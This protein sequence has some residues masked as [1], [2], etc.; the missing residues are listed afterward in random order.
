MCDARP[1][2]YVAKT[3]SS[4]RVGLRQVAHHGGR[5]KSVSEYLAELSVHWSRRRFARL[6]I[7]KSVEEALSHRHYASAWMLASLGRQ[8]C[9]AGIGRA[10]E[11][12]V[13]CGDRRG[14]E[15]A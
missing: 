11:E 15:A 8:L 14:R 13:R 6:P 2:F 4:R 9:V 12:A 1:G 7:V 3:S 5:L 10:V